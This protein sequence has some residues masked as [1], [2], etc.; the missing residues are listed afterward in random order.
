MD[1]VLI[2]YTLSLLNQDHFEML[3]LNTGLIASTGCYKKCLYQMKSVKVFYSIAYQY[4]G[5]WYIPKS[6]ILWSPIVYFCQ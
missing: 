3:L 5:I 2:K 4:I 6:M 1:S